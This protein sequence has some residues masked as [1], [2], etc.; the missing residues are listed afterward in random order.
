M[1][2][3]PENKNRYPKDWDSISYKI[4]FDRAKGK[5]EWCE[6]ENYKPHPVTGSKVILTVAHLN[7]TPEDCREENLVALCQRCHL[8]YDRHIHVKNRKENAENKKEIS[9]PKLF[10]QGIECIPLKNE[11]LELKREKPMS[12][13]LQNNLKVLNN[14][15]IQE[16]I[17]QALTYE[18]GYAFVEIKSDTDLLTA[19]NLVKQVKKDKTSFLNKVK[20][21]KQAVDDFKAKFLTREKQGEKSFNDFISKQDKEIE[22]YKQAKL[23][24]QREAKRK[25][26]EEAKRIS[27]ELKKQE[28]DRIS[29]EKAD[30]EK[31]LEEVKSED[32]S[33]EEKVEKIFEL[34]EKILDLESVI[35][36]QVEI[37]PEKVVLKKDEIKT[38][39]IFSIKDEKAFIEWAIQNNRELVTIQ[40][41]KSAFNE[42]IKSEEN[43]NHL[44]LE[45]TEEIV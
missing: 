2:I 8:N 34:N 20:P 37:K 12:L 6:A 39:K 42:W 35:V 43:Q 10:I 4:R 24:E 32:I 31:Q 27:D 22:K 9:Q 33:E 16:K 5:C 18:V 38:K 44:F 17:N 36:P 41:S 1:P 29:K 3:R 7:H 25:A 14:E 15:K 40:I 21:F 11:T 19:E 23:E 26:D 45:F 30:A 28:E 13:I